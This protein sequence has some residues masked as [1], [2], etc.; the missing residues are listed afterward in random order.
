MAPQERFKLPNYYRATLG[1]GAGRHNFILSAENQDAHK[2]V[3]S[4]LLNPDRFQSLMDHC[5]AQ[6][7]TAPAVR[8]QKNLEVELC[9]AEF[10]LSIALK[11]FW[12]FMYRPPRNWKMDAKTS[13]LL[14]RAGHLHT[15][16]GSKD[17]LFAISEL[18]RQG[19]S[20]LTNGK[21][22]ADLLALNEPCPDKALLASMF[23][24]N[25]RLLLIGGHGTSATTTTWAL[26]FLST[27]RDLQHALR[28]E[29]QRTLTSQP[30]SIKDLGKLEITKQVVNECLRLLPPGMATTRQVVSIDR[31]CGHDLASGSFIVIPFYAL[32]RHRSLW[33][34]PDQFKP[35]RFAPDAPQRPKR[36]AFL[37]FSAGAYS[38]LGARIGTLM[39]L[40]MLSGILNRWEVLPPQYAPYPELQIGAL[41]H[42]RAPLMLRLRRLG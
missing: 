32:H 3:L 23:H 36:G 12:H 11:S 38:C 27:R 31:L 28:D 37:P 2:A 14:N 10:V 5:D 9:A 42:P 41:L 20:L 1:P 40:A 26:W 16:V 39:S 18:V 13:D 22:E 21:D 4:V 30:F 34:D 19:T 35:E 7:E 33:S 24:D 15:K 25:G 8:M 6:I 17:P 29:I